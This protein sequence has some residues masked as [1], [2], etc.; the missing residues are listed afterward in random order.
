[1]S[2]EQLTLTLVVCCLI[3][4]IVN[5]IFLVPLIA[6][7]FFST[8]VREFLPVD[9]YA[10][11]Q[12]DLKQAYGLEPADK[13]AFA[14]GDL[15]LDIEELSPEDQEKALMQELQKKLWSGALMDT[16]G[17]TAPTKGVHQ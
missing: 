10:K 14:D 3:F 16:D 7:A 11:I 1:M 15:G 2:S 8:H 12:K 4:S 13:T 5:L 9:E 6:K 17:V